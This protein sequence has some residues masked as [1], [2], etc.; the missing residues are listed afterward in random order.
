M[1]GSWVWVQ[2]CNKSTQ[3]NMDLDLTWDIKKDLCSFR[4]K[5]DDLSCSF[6]EGNFVKN[7][8]LFQQLLQVLLFL[9][10]LYKNYCSISRVAK[11]IQLNTLCLKAFMKTQ[12]RNTCQPLEPTTMG[13]LW[14]VLQPLLW[15]F[16]VA[17]WL[18]TCSLTT[19]LNLFFFLP[20]GFFFFFF[21][22]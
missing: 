17:Q 20:C 11:C 5:V 7:V 16:A 14:T 6:H 8:C 13:C 3:L 9:L 4:S 12:E 22:L 18:G 21:S 10:L 15:F 2:L 19:F 1:E